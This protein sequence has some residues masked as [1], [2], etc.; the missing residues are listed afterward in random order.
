MHPTQDATDC[1][2]QT[3]RFQGLG[4][5]RVEA[6]FSGGH[7]SSDGGSLLLREVDGTHRICGELAGCFSDHRNQDFVEHVLAVMLRQRIMG[8]ALGYA[9]LKRQAG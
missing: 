9:A 8:I 6:D 2:Q 4:G 1:R 7:L 3:C 5:R